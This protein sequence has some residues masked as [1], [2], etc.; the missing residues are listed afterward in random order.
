MN[1]PGLDLF[2]RLPLAVR[3]AIDQRCGVFESAWQAG[4]PVS[5]ESILASA[6]PAER[7]ALLTELI[8]LDI[9]YRTAQHDPPQLA[10]YLARFPDDASLVARLLEAFPHSQPETI[11]FRPNFPM[12]KATL[13]ELP[14]YV[15]EAELGR[16]GMGVVYRAFDRTLKR[17]V[18]LKMVIDGRYSTLEMLARFRMEAELI[19]SLAHVNIVRVFGMGELD[20]HPFMALELLTGGTWATKLD[21]QPIAPRDAAEQISI[22]ANAIAHAHERKVIHRDLKPSNVLLDA[23]GTLK[24]SDF[25]LAKQQE[26]DAGMTE[27]GRILGTPGYMAP[28]QAKGESI[29]PACDIYAFGAMLYECLTGQPPFRGVGLNDILEQVIGREPIAPR[30]LQPGVPRDLETVCLK[31]LAKEPSARYE[32]AVELAADL[33]RFLDDTPV[34]ARPVGSIVR[35]GNWTRRNPVL[36]ILCA[37]IVLLPAMLTLMIGMMLYSQ[38]AD[39]GRRNAEK[40]RDDLSKSESQTRLALTELAHVHYLAN[41]GLAYRDWHNA[42]PTNA[43]RLLEACPNE[44]RG[45]E[46]SLVHSLCGTAPTDLGGHSASVWVVASS[47]DGQRIATSDE[48]GN[49]VIRDGTGKPLRTIPLRQRVWSLAFSPDRTVLAVGNVG[50]RLFDVESGKRIRDLPHPE[51]LVNGLAFTSDGSSLI[52]AGSDFGLNIV[53]IGW[54]RRPEQFRVRRWDWKTGEVVG[55]WKGMPDTALSLALSPDG[56]S[57]ATC[58]L[59]FA[60]VWDVAAGQMRRI[61]VAKQ[62]FRSIAF[63]AKGQILLGSLESRVEVWNATTLQ[64]IGTLPHPAGLFSITSLPDNRLVTACKDH[65]I[66]VWDLGTL[67]TTNILS[68]HSAD[69]SS[70]AL[71]PNGQLV[72]GGFDHSVRMWSI[73]DQQEAS[74]FPTGIRIDGIATNSMADRYFVGTSGG[75]VRVYTPDGTIEHIIRSGTGR[76]SALAVSPDGARIAIATSNDDVAICDTKTGTIMR[77]LAATNDVRGLA[78]TPEGTSILTIGSDLSIWSAETGEKRRSLPG[79]LA[80]ALSYDGKRVASCVGGEVRIYDFAS[81]ETIARCKVALGGSPL[82]AL[83]PD[84]GLIAVADRDRDIQVFDVEHFETPLYVDRT[85]AGAL[86]HLQF[87]GDGRRLWFTGDDS[88]VRVVDARSGMETLM[89]TTGGINVLSATMDSSDRKLVVGLGNGKVRVWSTGMLMR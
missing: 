58:G 38:E 89:L 41:I 18:A 80:L 28:E 34:R 83:S 52:T 3:H 79:K 19:A 82:L 88:M 36:A 23:D 51:Q 12:F 17:S 71:L 48:P 20:G 72:S 84:G 77:R 67:S 25:G 16:G 65:A 29:S 37:F 10:E 6:S 56:K 47:L 66:R 8:L 50:V 30:V 44:L 49:I 32:S 76:I 5:V 81:G 40:A 2:D 43:L 7:P 1:I 63:G 39:R 74:E 55:T 42:L 45:W 11:V 27:K 69:V 21:G 4:R 70:I 22:L 53:G 64:R 62:W 86:Q 35:T 26:F 31:C 60:C 85:H 73:D 46:W 75:T 15:V 57:I 33:S 61:P 9:E 87:S 14:G 24:I 59:N 54:K 68:G 78:W 13:P